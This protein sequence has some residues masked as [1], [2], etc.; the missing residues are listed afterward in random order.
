VTV[1]L[2]TGTIHYASPAHFVQGI[3]EGT[4]VAGHVAQ[5]DSAM[6]TAL[7]TEL[8]SVLLPYASSQGLVAPITANLAYACK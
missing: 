6:R 5:F 7:L 2:R 4:P 1:S 3:V 8:E